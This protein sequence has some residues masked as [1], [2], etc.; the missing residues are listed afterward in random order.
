MNP[1]MRGMQNGSQLLFGT[2]IF[3]KRI[4]YSAKQLTYYQCN[5]I[6]IQVSSLL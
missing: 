5:Q 2:A 1:R 4:H 6:V 3:R